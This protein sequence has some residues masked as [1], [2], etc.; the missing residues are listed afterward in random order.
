MWYGNHVWPIYNLDCDLYNLKLFEFFFSE[1]YFLYCWRRI[2]PVS[3]PGSNSSS[4]LPQCSIMSLSRK[5]LLCVEFCVIILLHEWSIKG[6]CTNYE[7][8][9]VCNSDF[10]A[11]SV[12]LEFF[13]VVC[14]PYMGPFMQLTE[15]RIIW[16]IGGFF[17]TTTITFSSKM[18]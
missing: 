15:K 17:V 2:F 4:S 8:S 11:T 10:I 3:S 1:N 5:N 13:K 16:H 18:F 6:R 12:L 9:S 7:N 14:L